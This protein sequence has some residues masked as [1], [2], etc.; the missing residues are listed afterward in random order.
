[1]NE[2][3]IEGKRLRLRRA[4][5]TDLGY[6][7]TLQFA[8]ENLKFIVPFDEN[9]HREIINSDG[10]HTRYRASTGNRHCSL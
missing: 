1:M 10:S 5:V 3:L 9:Y 7:M 4:N 8:P 2:T 6:I